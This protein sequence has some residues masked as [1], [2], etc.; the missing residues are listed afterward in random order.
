[1]AEIMCLPYLRETVHD[2]KTGD[3]VKS[4]LQT[5]QQFKTWPSPGKKTWEKNMTSVFLVWVLQLLLNPSLA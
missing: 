1:M 4:G 3:D 2:L 5:Y